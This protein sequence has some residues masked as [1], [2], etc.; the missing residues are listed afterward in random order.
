MKKQVH[1][2]GKRGP[3]TSTR[4]GP[5]TLHI[6]NIQFGNKNMRATLG[7]FWWGFHV[8]STKGPWMIDF[9]QFSMNIEVVKMTRV[10]KSQIFNEKG[11]HTYL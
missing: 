8:A 7:I 10:R 4:V 11:K 5:C 1:P 3:W 6:A 9:I 2:K